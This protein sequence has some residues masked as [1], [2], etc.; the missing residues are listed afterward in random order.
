MSQLPRR[1]GLTPWVLVVALLAVSCGDDSG[2]IG[3]ELIDP[4]GRLVKTIYPGAVEQG[5]GSVTL[6]PATA[7][8]SPAYPRQPFSDVE[9][10]PALPAAAIKSV[11]GTKHRL[12]ELKKSGAGHEEPSHEK[13]APDVQ[14]GSPEELPL[15][16]YLVT[17]GGDDKLTLDWPSGGVSASIE[18]PAGAV[19]PGTA[20]SMQPIQ[21]EEYEHR[22]PGVVVDGLAFRLLPHGL[23]FNYPVLLTVHYQSQLSMD[24]RYALLYWDEA[25]HNYERRPIVMKDIGS[26]SA[27]FSLNHF[28]DYSL[29]YTVVE[30]VWMKRKGG[31]DWQMRTYFEGWPGLISAVTVHLG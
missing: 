31:S 11:L 4:H 20:I 21:P 17:S 30:A 19:A 12:H 16:S 9:Q 28:S 6:A 26:N 24:E 22:T 18:I 15:P 10:E 29:V 1:W 25:A 8:S 14:S 5:H 27:V 13:P 23:K 7:E 2:K 3:D